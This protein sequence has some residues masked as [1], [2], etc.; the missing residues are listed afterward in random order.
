MQRDLDCKQN[1]RYNKENF[2]TKLVFNAVFDTIKVASKNHGRV[3][4]GFVRDVIV[5]IENEGY[6]NIKDYKFKDIDLWFQTDVDAENFIIQMGDKFVYVEN[7]TVDLKSNIDTMNLYPFSRKQYHLVLYN[8]T[9]AWFDIIVN[10]TIPVDDFDINTLTYQIN[11][12]KFKACSYGSKSEEVLKNSIVEK[13]A[14]VLSSYVDRMRV[15]CYPTKR[16]QHRYIERGW[17]ICYQNL[18]FDNSEKL[19]SFCL[20]DRNDI[21]INKKKAIEPKNGTTEVKMF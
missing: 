2:G 21:K 20:K 8:I 16:L 12:D 15:H 14:E 6:E 17:K 10:D 11:N 13:K 3:F 19:R 4:G 18:T 7:A 9:I 1:D 5:R